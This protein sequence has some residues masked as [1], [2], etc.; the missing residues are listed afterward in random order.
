[1]NEEIRTKSDI[2]WK[3]ALSAYFKPFMELCW[4]EIYHDINWEK[5]YEVKRIGKRGEC[6]ELHDVS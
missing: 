2:A 4:Q 5:G 1:M 3:E 6:C